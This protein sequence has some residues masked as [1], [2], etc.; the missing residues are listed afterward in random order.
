MQP[1]ARKN[2]IIGSYGDCLKIKIAAPPVE[3]AANDEIIRFFKTKLKISSS[4]ISLLK[5][6]G[7][8]KKLL[9]IAGI[10]KEEF[11]SKI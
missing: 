3:G 5:G 4:R 10:S 11:L 9:Y 6:Q 2:E 1:N 8:K 7:S